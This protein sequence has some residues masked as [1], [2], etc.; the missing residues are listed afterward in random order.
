MLNQ[1]IRIVKKYV[2]QAGINLNSDQMDGNSEQ[3]TSWYRSSN[4]S[5]QATRWAE[6]IALT[7][8]Y[9]ETNGLTVVS[10][11][12]FNEPDYTAW[13][14]GSK[15][16]MLAICRKLREDETYKNDFANVKLC[17]GNTLNNDRAWEWYDYSKRY[18]DEG[19][20]HQLAGSFD[21][22]ASFYEG[23]RADGKVGV[24]DELHNILECMVGSEYGMTKGIWWG[25]AEHT[26]SQFMKATRGTRMG[27]AE[28]R[29]KWTAASVYRHTD[30]SVQGF[31]GTSERQA[32]E[33]VY[34]FAAMAQRANT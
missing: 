24:G 10:V 11:S 13:H 25:T 31:G 20:T 18:L 34:R 4:S 6:L 1:R 30:G 19:N 7:K 17:G 32:Y 12:P 29:D 26:R 22:F 27:Y 21:N 3:V 5:T 2:P 28:N 23:V 33:T 9:V 14:Q 15:A 8:A 16:D